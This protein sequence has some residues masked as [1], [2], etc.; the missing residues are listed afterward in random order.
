MKMCSSIWNFPFTALKTSLFKD[1]WGRDTELS[2]INRAGW[3]KDF[4]AIFI[5]I[6]ILLLFVFPLAFVFTIVMTALVIPMQCI[7][8]FFN[9]TGGIKGPDGDDEW[10]VKFGVTILNILK[11]IAAVIGFFIEGIFMVVGVC[12]LLGVWFWLIFTGMHEKKKDG[13]EIVKKTWI[14]MVWDYKFIWAALAIGLWASK[15]EDY[16]KNPGNVL[17]FIESKWRKKLPNLIVV[18]TMIL[19]AKQQHGFFKMLT[20]NPMNRTKIG[21]DGNPKA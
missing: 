2:Q 18:A 5:I 20:I 3:I 12:I 14:N 6:P 7:L 15:F 1:K 13:F 21:C 11:M 16:L 17:N 4:M 9:T 8:I 10:Y 19:L